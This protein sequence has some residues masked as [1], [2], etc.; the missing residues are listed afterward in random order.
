MEEEPVNLDSRRG[1]AAQTATEI[2]RAEAQVALDQRALRRRRARLERALLASPARNWREASERAS[3]LIGL[4]MASADGRDP[5]RRRLAA[6]IL[7]DFSRLLETDRQ[8]LEQERS[9]NISPD[10]IPK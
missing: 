6:A 7:N 9:E 4:F 5:R 10:D 2:R 8:G 1:M 3:Y